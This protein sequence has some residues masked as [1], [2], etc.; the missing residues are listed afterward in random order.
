MINKRLSFAI[1]HSWTFPHSDISF[2]EK[3]MRKDHI[4]YNTT[5]KSQ[6]IN[7]LFIF[8]TVLRNTTI[9]TTGIWKLDLRSFTNWKFVQVSNVQWNYSNSWWFLSVNFRI[10]Q[11]LF[12]QNIGNYFLNI[13][14]HLSDK[15]MFN[16]IFMDNNRTITWYFTV[17]APETNILNIIGIM[18]VKPFSVLFSSKI[19]KYFH[20]YR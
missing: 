1:W 3:V 20:K 4:F 13:N 11:H 18:R 14:V 10:V 19:L 9:L 12:F 7:S 17:T 6:K 8:V 2:E 15:D 16:S 5:L